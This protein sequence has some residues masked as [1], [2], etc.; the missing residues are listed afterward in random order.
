MIRGTPACRELAR[1]YDSGMTVAKI[2]IS[3]AQHQLAAAQDAVREG[4]A[5]SVSAYI[6]RA[7]ERHLEAESLEALVRDLIAEHGAPTSKDRAWAKRVL[8]RRRA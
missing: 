5:P 3:L 7:I 4:R 2:A 6:G 1:G 8:K